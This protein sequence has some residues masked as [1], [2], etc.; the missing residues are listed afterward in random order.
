MKSAIWTSGTKLAQRGSMLKFVLISNVVFTVVLL[1]MGSQAARPPPYRGNCSTCE[2]WRNLCLVKC[3]QQGI[4]TKTPKKS[5]ECLRKCPD[6]ESE[7]C[8]LCKECKNSKECKGCDD[9]KKEAYPYLAK[10]RTICIKC[11]NK[12]N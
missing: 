7:V 6:M 12:C 3:K 1:M 2:N 5:E 10:C 9:C 4:D 11:R 8:K